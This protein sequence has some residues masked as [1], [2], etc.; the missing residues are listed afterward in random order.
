M[1]SVRISMTDEVAIDIWYI[2]RS[3]LDAAFGMPEEQ[4]KRLDDVAKRLAEK[5]GSSAKRY[6]E[7]HERHSGTG[8]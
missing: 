2:L 8:Q 5:I 7:E 4:W 6:E 3:T 1:S